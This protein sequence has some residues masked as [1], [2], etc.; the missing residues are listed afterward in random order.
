VDFAFLVAIIYEAKRQMR[1]MEK[2]ERRKVK[3]EG[4]KG[5]RQSSEGCKS[6]KFVA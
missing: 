3:E 1:R 5:W 2:E 6:L 4:N